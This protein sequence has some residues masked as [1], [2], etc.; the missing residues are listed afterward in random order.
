MLDPPSKPLADGERR[1]LEQ[2]LALLRQSNEREETFATAWFLGKVALRLG[3]FHDAADALERAHAI[4]PNQV[5]G[6]SELGAAYLELDRAADALRLAHR[7]LEL[8]PT[9]ADLRCNLALALLLTGDVQAARTEASAALA[10]N[11]ADEIARVLLGLIDDVAAGRRARP[12]SLA[13]AEGRSA[14]RSG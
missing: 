1:A 4:D 11:P 6:C 13:E 2:A 9:D 5:D 3:R 8:R 14:P 7:A 12:T 10:T